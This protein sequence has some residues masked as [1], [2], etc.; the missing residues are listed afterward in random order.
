MQYIF[1][2]LL[3]LDH[4][5]CKQCINAAHCYRC[6]VVCVLGT[7]V[8]YARTTELIE[9]RIGTRLMWVQGNHVLDGG[10]SISDK[11][12]RCWEWWQS[13]DAAFWQI[14]LGICCYFNH[15]HHFCKWA[16]APL[17]VGVGACS[18]PCCLSGSTSSC[19]GKLRKLKTVYLSRLTVARPTID[20]LKPISMTHNIRV[21]TQK[22]TRI[23][24]NAWMNATLLHTWCVLM[25]WWSIP[26]HCWPLTWTQSML[27]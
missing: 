25:T 16:S 6:R 15:H 22:L 14:T 1:I 19:D 17:S 18:V 5:T 2:L 24:S 7:R 8:N 20:E 21:F 26:S 27:T 10:G 23:Q 11:S 3:L 12:I 13:G 9:I 4:I